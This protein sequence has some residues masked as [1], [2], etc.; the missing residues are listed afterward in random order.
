MIVRKWRA[1]DAEKMGRDETLLNNSYETTLNFPLSN[2]ML[3][4]TGVAPVKLRLAGTEN[5]L[6]VEHR[7]SNIEDASLFRFYYKQ[8]QE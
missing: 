5:R 6:N 3:A 4:A 7:T 8:A 1:G 2:W